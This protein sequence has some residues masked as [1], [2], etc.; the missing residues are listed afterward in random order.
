MN[1]P[2]LLP[3]TKLGYRRPEAAAFV[4]VSPTTFDRWVEAGDMPAPRKIGGITIWRADELINA[5][6]KL[7]GAETGRLEVKPNAWDE[8]L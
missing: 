8:T 3:I 4:G 7:T 2:V 1:A 6:N 5:F